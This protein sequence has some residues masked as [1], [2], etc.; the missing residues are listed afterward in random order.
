MEARRWFF[1]T[2]GSIVVITGVVVAGNVGLDVYGL[3]RDAHGRHLPAF[4]DD[5]VAKYL[6]S[7][8]YVPANFDAILIG[9]SVSANWNTR[10]IHALRVY[11]ESMSAA[12]IV[13]E[14]ALVDRALSQPGIQVAMLIVHPYLT[15]S[16]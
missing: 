6:L 15:N 14:K 5:R 10:K 8:N 2:L 7:N 11:N 3:F 16:H 4:G 1:T 9:T 12:N 13:E